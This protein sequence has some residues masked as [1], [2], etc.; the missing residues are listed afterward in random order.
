M[1]RDTWKLRLSC[2]M[3][4]WHMKWSKRNKLEVR[5]IKLKSGLIL[6]ISTRPN[7]TELSKSSSN[8]ALRVILIKNMIGLQFLYN[9]YI[10]STIFFQINH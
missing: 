8:S 7:K 4:T 10:I 2:C 1:A 6:Y 5:G 9:S 3:C